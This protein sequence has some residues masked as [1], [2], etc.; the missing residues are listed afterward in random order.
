M[1]IEKL[2]KKY[3]NIEEIPESELE[4]AG[5]VYYNGEIMPRTEMERLM[6][7]GFSEEYSPDFSDYEDIGYSDEDYGIKKIEE[8]LNPLLNG[9]VGKYI[10][11]AFKRELEEGLEDEMGTIAPEDEI[12]ESSVIT[13]LRAANNY[14]EKHTPI[15]AVIRKK[16]FIEE[17]GRDFYDV[18]TGGYY[19]NELPESFFKEAENKALEELINEFPNQEIPEEIKKEFQEKYG[20]EHC[21]HASFLSYAFQKMVLE[22]KNP[23]NFYGKKLSDLKKAFIEKFKDIQGIEDFADGIYYED[24]YGERLFRGNWGNKGSLEEIINGVPRTVEEFEENREGHGVAIGYI[25]TDGFCI[26]DQWLSERDDLRRILREIHNN[27]FKEQIEQKDKE[28]E[29]LKEHVSSKGKREKIIRLC[30]DYPSFD[31]YIRKK[32]EGDNG[33]LDSLKENKKTTQELKKLGIKTDIFYNGIPEMGFIV[34]R[35]SIMNKDQVKKTY[36][37]EYKEVMKN[38]LDSKTL[39]QPKRLEQKL[40]D[41]IDNTQNRE[42]FTD[43]LFNLNDDDLLR[44][45]CNTCIEYAS[46]KQN[47]K[48]EQKAVVVRHH[49]RNIINFLKGKHKNGVQE[50]EVYSVKL[51]SKNPFTDIDIGNDAGCCIGI[52]GEEDFDEN[53]GDYYNCVDRFISSLKKEHNP[54]DG[55]GTYMPFY[56]KDRATQ[57]LEIYKGKE[58]IGLG[59]MFAG[60]NERNEPTL[61]LNSIELSDKVKS[62]PNISGVIEKALDYAREYATK[63]GFKHV[64][65][66]RHG[67]NVAKDFSSGTPDFNTAKKIHNWKEEV[68]TDLQEEAKN[69]GKL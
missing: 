14:L 67:Y 53:D 63:S 48:D 42:N 4:R 28:Y 35:D 33:Y 45:V 22:E 27:E 32:A 44:K 24:Y 38:L 58:R 9:K 59:L 41:S 34:D 64:L 56:L 47:V 15:D 6:E 30:K 60:K 19:D 1:N 10:T 17:V 11:P 65:M 8:V 21:L 57:F 66:G 68:Y 13:F 18:N 2:I 36:L 16:N 29:F 69:L 43:Y 40:F 20:K 50:G 23:E 25:V 52:Y 7:E 62:N 26:D 39:I 61:L 54:V 55:N 31:S 49:F 5:Y 12:K 51:A 37:E 46:K 3:G